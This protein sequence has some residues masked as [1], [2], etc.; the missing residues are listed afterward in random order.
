VGLLNDQ[1][2]DGFS[3]DPEEM[4]KAGYDTIAPEY[5]KT[6]REDSEDGLLLQE[7]VERLPKGAKVLDAGCGAGDGW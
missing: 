4:V 5:L 3:M 1:Q 7:L 2:E 6:R